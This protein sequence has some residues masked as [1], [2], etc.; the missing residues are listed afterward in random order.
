MS[1]TLNIYSDESM[2]EVKRVAEADKLKIPYRVA[3]YIIQSLDTVDITN[4]TDLLKFVT[5]NVGMVDK[6]LKATFALSDSELDCV[7]G[8]ELVEVI[9]DLFSWG[10]AKI[11]SLK[12]GNA[13]K[14]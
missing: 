7:D 5:S 6:I 13:E 8:A 4:D 1:L 3:T 9:K 10:L 2:T 14:N 12:S 11:N